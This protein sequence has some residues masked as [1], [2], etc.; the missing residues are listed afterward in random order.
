[1]KSQVV[2]SASGGRGLA[3]IGLAAVVVWV[4]PARDARANPA[5]AGRYTLTQ[6]TVQDS[7]TKL[8]WQRDFAPGMYVWDAS[9]PP[10]SAQAYCKDLQLLGGGWRLPT[11]FELQTIVD[12]GVAGPAID[13]SV[14]PATPGV[15]GSFD[16]ESLFWSSTASVFEGYAWSVF[17]S[18]G[19]ADEP[20]VNIQGH[21]RC[22]R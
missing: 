21:V 12:E 13:K 9:A 7:D 22:V 6:D 3:V 8:T 5:C 20:L 19:F 11:V 4:L 2:A 15:A 18:D 16:T 17:F 14:F 1:M 10:L